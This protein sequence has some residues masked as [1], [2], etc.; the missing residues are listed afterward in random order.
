M[1]IRPIQPADFTYFDIPPFSAS[2]NAWV[3]EDSAPIGYAAIDPVP[4][5]TH[6]LDLYGYIDPAY[7]RQGYGST[8]LN[9]VRA[10]AKRVAG[11]TQLSALVDSEMVGMKPFLEKHHFC[12]EHLEYELTLSLK[13]RIR[14]NGFTLKQLPPDQAASKLRQLYDV[15]F[16]D[17][18]WYQ[19]YIDDSEL[20]GNLGRDGQIYF[21]ESMGE[22]VGFAGVAYDADR[23]EIEPFG[24]MPAHRGEGF[25][26]ILLNAL[27]HT[28][29]ERHSRIAHLTVWAENTPALRLYESVGFVRRDMRQFMALD[30]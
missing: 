24:V 26:R 29:M 6:I 10:E 9:F 13:D 20:L 11:A 5:L 4:G 27:L 8:F 19:P 3:L 1:V 18:A 23:A 28:F 12:N 16:R 21:L 30:L 17:L 2:A 14:P 22:V 25:G 7:R 15:S